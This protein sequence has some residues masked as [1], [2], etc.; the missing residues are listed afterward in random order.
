M[1]ESA[2]KPD[3]LEKKLMEALVQQQAKFEAAMTALEQELSDVKSELEV[4]VEELNDLASQPRSAPEE[5]IERIDELEATKLD[6]PTERELRKREEDTQ[7]RAD[8]DAM[9]ERK[10][11]Q[12]LDDIEL[13]LDRIEE[14]PCPFKEIVDKLNELEQQI[15]C[16]QDQVRSR[17]K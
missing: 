15:R 1:S 13:R 4:A 3:D 17:L 7:L 6:A 11:E 8:E 5:L 2:P 16:L 12:R 9:L 10:K 14:K